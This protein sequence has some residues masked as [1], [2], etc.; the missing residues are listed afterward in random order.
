MQ[1]T[2]SGAVGDVREL[3]HKSFLS[4]RTLTRA[5]VWLLFNGLLD[6][7]FFCVTSFLILKS[8]YTEDELNLNV[9]TSRLGQGLEPFFVF[10]NLILV[11]LHLQASELNS[12]SA[13]T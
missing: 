4:T 6:L 5:G 2:A 11:F 1:S 10:F 9:Q 7:V 13:S 8:S 3:Q 12:G